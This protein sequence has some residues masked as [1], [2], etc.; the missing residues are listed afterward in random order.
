MTIL[1]QKRSGFRTFFRSG[2]IIHV[3][4][5]L[6][7]FLI[8]IQISLAQEQDWNVMLNTPSG[9]ELYLE[10]LWW[11][12]IINFRDRETEV[13]LFGEIFEEQKGDMFRGRSNPI[14][15]PPGG[16]NITPADITE[17]KDRWIRPEFERSILRSGRFP[18][19]NYTICITVV[20]PENDRPLGV[21]CINRLVSMP[22]A[23][24]LIMPENDGTVLEEYPVFQW[25]EPSPLPPDAPVFYSLKIA[26][27]YRGQTIYEAIDNIPHL[28]E[29]HLEINFFQ[30]PLRGLRFEPEKTYV[31]QVQTL[32]MDGRPIGEND[33][34]SE[35][36]QFRVD[37]SAITRV[38]PLRH[39]CPDTLIMG[40]FKLAV[41]SCRFN[42]DS[43]L[44]GTAKSCF[45]TP[46]CLIE[47]SVSPMNSVIPGAVSFTRQYKKTCFTIDFDRLRPQNWPPDSV[48]TIQKG[49]IDFTGSRSL[50]V[51]VDDFNVLLQKLHITPD[52]ARANVAV[53]VPGQYLY[54]D[55]DCKPLILDLGLTDV[56]PLLQLYFKNTG[57]QLDSL[58][59][60]N[61]GILCNTRGLVVDFT[62]SD[63][64]I[65]FLSGRTLPQKPAGPTNQG[66]LTAE[67]TFANAELIGC[68]GLK[69]DLKLYN[70][71]TFQTLV[72]WQFTLSLQQ[73]ELSL[74]KSWVIKG[75]FSGSLVTSKD[76]NQQMV[77]ASF[78]SLKIDSL[79]NGSADVALD[80]KKT[81]AW[82][83]FR[84]HKRSGNFYLPGIENEFRTDPVDT[85]NTTQYAKLDLQKIR[86]ALQKRP[87]LSFILGIQTPADS[88]YIDSPDK[89]APIGFD[90]NNNIVA[91][92][93][94]L[95][96]ATGGVTGQI[97][98]YQMDQPKKETYGYP[99]INKF[100]KSDSAFKA[101]IEHIPDSLFWVDF[102]FVRNAVFDAY[103]GGTLKIP[104]PC[105]F[106][107]KYKDMEVTSTAEMVGGDVF[108]KG[109]T[110]Q[111][112]GV[113]MTA[114]KEGNVLSV[115]TGE[116][117][118]MNS[119]IKE[120]I[121][122]SKSFSILWGEM[123]ADGGLG[124]FLFDYNS[125]GQQFDGFAF[126]LHDAFLSKYRAKK[127]STIPDTLGYLRAYGNVHFDYFGAKL[128]D[129]HDYKDS[130]STHQKK[131]Y[132]K[133]FVTLN[134][135]KSDLHFDQTW[136][137]G[138]A[139]MVFDVDYDNNLKKGDQNGFK[140][141]PKKLMKVD[142]KLSSQS[143]TQ[144]LTPTVIDMNS[145]T[146]FIHFCETGS[147]GLIND[148]TIGSV[149]GVIQVKGD[150][151]KRIALEG[152]VQMKDWNFISNNLASLEITPNN[153]TF[154]YRGE[155]SF[156]FLSVGLFGMVSERLV[157]DKKN[158]SLDG[159][160]S[161]MFRVYSG[162]NL[163]IYTPSNSD[164][165]N[166]EAQGR[167]NYHIGLDANYIQGYARAKL[168]FG[169]VGVEGEGAFFFGFNAP[170]NKI[171][172][173]DSIVKGGKIS[174]ILTNR[175]FTNLTGFYLAGSFSY[176]RSIY[177]ISGGIKMWA[178]F[179]FFQQGTNVAFIGHGG[180]QLHGELFGGFIYASAWVDLLAAAKFN[181][182]PTNINDFDFCLQGTLGIEACFIL[183]CVDL[184]TTVHINKY[185]LL[186]PDGCD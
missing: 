14:F 144:M 23:P 82:G 179:G 1:N 154:Q 37:P 81:L 148:V 78:A 56:D 35:I 119:G 104:Y 159:D 91:L 44:S 16:R 3:L 156:T 28:Q 98:S 15:I 53:Q 177:I 74:E 109:D 85:L 90:F 46:T 12:D 178:G 92:Q 162:T 13:M 93:G 32:D 151:L 140:G 87:G 116:I 134:K 97:Q 38:P 29:Q 11:A 111:Y 94:W 133:R 105:N 122:F 77:S 158:M 31:W 130:T 101:T 65:E 136:G 59:I 113:E 100:Y 170:V 150:S 95:N 183:W 63:N 120:K 52:S 146:S 138:T 57:Y 141:E 153:V 86:T 4:L 71:W 125:A 169:G 117:I 6:I 26:E 83:G 24:R 139:H 143:N 76:S 68:F 174:D 115:D 182:L 43:T 171:F 69:A 131:P 184:E 186:L 79:L 103:I 39:N 181:V 185:G 127:V 20:S 165:M 22:G 102:K 73:G 96:I 126:T 62:G 99:K 168:E 110:L 66:F 61:T 8:P 106:T 17:I 129:I 54:N 49:T 175:G 42:N 114:E 132:Y 75:S 10:D 84:L 40:D 19:G 167:F 128:M 64:K 164:Y 25:T 41:E 70:T 161:A 166:C 30:Y 108:F 149:S 60:G 172:A 88:F 176:S 163:V 47:G 173:L 152:G 36:W 89:K 80:E 160:I 118:Y 9:Y 157:L 112:W 180:L 18:A 27:V 142:F 34:K 55:S 121:H 155:A 67:Y 147:L 107:A 72:P 124:R 45:A 145:G 48:V 21:S 7:Y 50:T 137:L 135:K 51:P 33:G 2:F 58:I 123:L 5:Y